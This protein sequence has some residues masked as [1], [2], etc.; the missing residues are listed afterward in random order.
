MAL[1]PEKS[2]HS[3]SGNAHSNLPRFGGDFLSETSLNTSFNYHH[4]LTQKFK[5]FL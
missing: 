3:F 2:I 5:G 1:V 4:Q